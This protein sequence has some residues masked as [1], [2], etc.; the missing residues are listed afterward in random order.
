MLDSRNGRHYDAA[1]VRLYPGGGIGGTV[2]EE[3]VLV[4]PLS[5]L[6]DMGVEI[7]DGIQVSQAVCVSVDGELCGVFA[8]SYEKTKSATAGLSTLSSYRKLNPM[9]IAGEFMVAEE[10]IRKKFSIK[11]KRLLFPD[12][13]T[14]RELRMIQPEE[15]AEALGSLAIGEKTE[16]LSLENGWYTV[17]PEGYLPEHILR[18]PEDFLIVIDP[19]HQGKGNS[20]KEPIGPGASEKKPKVASGTEGAATGLPEY[21]LT[22]EVS[23]KLRDALEGKGYRVEMIRTS[24]DVNISNAQRAQIAN[25]Q[26]A[27][28]FIRI[29]ANGDSNP[30]TNGIMTL[31]Q[32]KSNPYN[33][34]LYDRSS[35]LSTLVLDEMVAATG[36]NRQFVWE[37]DTMSGINWCQV[38]VTIVEM[39]YM[40]NPEEDR[41][42]STAEYQQKLV[43][44]MVNGIEAYLNAL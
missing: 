16:I 3:P 34:H 15:G 22:L 6:K 33:A 1:H 19:G 14:R 11:S 25:G 30:Q 29:H 9:M 8:I 10:F 4:G 20:E 18:E 21:K 13:Q 12:E 26:Y 42:M 2:L 36:A 28:V 31:C 17:F 35:L 43:E 5:F 32:T 41:L 24:H 27:D 37:T 40:S 44:G 39:G 23:L 38:P 7:P